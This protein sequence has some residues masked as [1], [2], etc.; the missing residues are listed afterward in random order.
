MKVYLINEYE[1]TRRINDCKKLIK[2]VAVAGVIAFSALSPLGSL[3]NNNPI[4]FLEPIKVEAS[5]KKF[6]DVDSSKWFYDEVNTLVDKGGIAGYTDGSFKPQGTITRGEFLKIALCS[7]TNK[8]Y[9]KEENQVHW[10]SGVLEEAYDLGIVTRSEWEG[11]AE[12]LNTPITRNEMA[13]ILVRIDDK[14]LMTGEVNTN[15][16]ENYLSDYKQIP[17][18]YRG[19]VGQAVTKGLLTGYTDGS[20]GG[21]K[22]GTRAEASAM[23]VRLINSNDRVDVD[24][25]K[26]NPNQKTPLTNANNQM[27]FEYVRAYEIQALNTARTYQQ[28]GNVYLEITLPELPEDYKWTP[29]VTV[30]SKDGNYLYSSYNKNAKGSLG[31]ITFNL[32]KGGDGLSTENGC[33]PGVTPA[34]IKAGAIL[35]LDLKITKAGGKGSHTGDIAYNS[36]TPDAM[37]ERTYD[38]AGSTLTSLVIPKAEF[39]VEGLKAGWK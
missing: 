10:A 30:T 32:T 29:G 22:T 18:Q 4:S 14:I 9:P 8:Q 3:G 28:N 17:S 24:V 13:R 1:K 33:K 19:F 2:G 5:N 27:N 25:T 16:V 36:S 39:S 35:E 12:S 34:D 23:V 26:P 7:A 15:G 31:T 21:S 6:T 11:S 20:Y 37:R 38:G